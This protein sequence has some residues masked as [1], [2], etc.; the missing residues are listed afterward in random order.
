MLSTS[1]GGLV[2][3]RRPNGQRQSTVGVIKDDDDSALKPGTQLAGEA[4]YRLAYFGCS[5]GPLSE[6]LIARIN[7]LITAAGPRPPWLA[8]YLEWLDE[9]ARARFEQEFAAHNPW[10][11]VAQP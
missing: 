6:Q 7:A 9:A 2:E 5:R 11:A 1:S 3:S 4:I 10:R 8:Y